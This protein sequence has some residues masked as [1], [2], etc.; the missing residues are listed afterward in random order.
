MK[1]N[2]SIFDPL[3]DFSNYSDKDLVVILETF[4]LSFLIKK[5]KQ[6]IAYETYLNDKNNTPYFLYGFDIKD[7]ELIQNKFR[8]LIFLIVSPFH[9]YIPAEEFNSLLIEKYITFNFGEQSTLHYTYDKID[10][11]NLN[12]VYAFSSNLYNNL[13]NH[14]P[15]APFYHAKTPL[16]NYFSKINKGGESLYV[17]VRN[18]SFDLFAYKNAAFQLGNTYTYNAA[19]DFI[20]FLMFAVKQ[21]NFDAKNLQLFLGG[22]IDKDGSIYDY[23]Y[24]YIRY[25]SFIAPPEGITFSKNFE[26]MPA[27]YFINAII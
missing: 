4:S 1:K 17:C 26:N 3:S 24:K 21:L 27:H 13:K 8:S 19:Q 7:V 2:I 18:N 25:P 23:I 14:F 22:N 10:S 20:Y 16:L 12:N 15:D 9:T 11:L 5:E 6:V